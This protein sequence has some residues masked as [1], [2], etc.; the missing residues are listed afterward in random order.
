MGKEVKSETRF[1]RKTWFLTRH[2]N[3]G[4]ILGHA[5]TLVNK[6]VGDDVTGL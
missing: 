6:F 1:F 5:D 2:M 4:G 3:F